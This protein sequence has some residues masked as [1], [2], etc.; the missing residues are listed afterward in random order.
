VK[1]A[2]GGG[3]SNVLFSEKTTQLEVYVSPTFL[4]VNER[5]KY[6]L[7]CVD[8]TYNMNS[9]HIEEG[10]FKTYIRVKSK[11]G[12]IGEIEKIYDNKLLV[13]YTDSLVAGWNSE[14]KFK[15][16]ELDINDVEKLDN[17]LNSPWIIKI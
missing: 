13:S 1:G 4:E 11:C 14:N 17:G 12:I 3:V 6:S 10:M 5:F 16:L 8:V 15:Q 9:K 7:E 2:I